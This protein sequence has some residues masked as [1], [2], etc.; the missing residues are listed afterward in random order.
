M[1]S[2]LALAGCAAIGMPRTL[3]PQGKIPIYLSPTGQP[4]RDSE[5][6]TWD[7]YRASDPE[8][9]FLRVNREPLR[10]S[11]SAGEAVL[12]FVDRG[13]DPETDYYYY[14]AVRDGGTS[15][16]TTRIVR[17]RPVI[18]ADGTSGPNS[19]G[20]PAVRF[21]DPSQSDRDT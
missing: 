5:T 10:A 9:P 7:V 20:T 13:L 11:A 3:G 8:G 2:V 14:L 6:T 21:G 18:P 16:K 12:L 19:A 4:S 17:A 15:R 1:F